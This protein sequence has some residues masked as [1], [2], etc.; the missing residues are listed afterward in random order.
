MFVNLQV[1]DIV[2]SRRLPR[3]CM[4]S[5]TWVLGNNGTESA[6]KDFDLPLMESDG[7]RKW[8]QEKACS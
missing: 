1:Y 7:F 6:V 4:L 2:G 5:I 3:F 8:P